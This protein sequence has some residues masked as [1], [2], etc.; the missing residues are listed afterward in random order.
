MFRVIYDDP[1]SRNYSC[2]QNL[3]LVDCAEGQDDV[4]TL[5][6]GGWVE[7]VATRTA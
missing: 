2:R 4:Q 1:C 5:L 6:S 3:S 7:I